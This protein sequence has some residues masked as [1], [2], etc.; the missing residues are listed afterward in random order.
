MVLCLVLFLF[1]FYVFYFSSLHSLIVLLFVESFILG[2]LVFLF[3][4]GFS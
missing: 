1:S 2:C 4:L 3:F